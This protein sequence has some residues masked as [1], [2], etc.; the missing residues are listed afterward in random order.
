MDGK[1]FSKNFPS[2][3]PCTTVVMLY[4][5]WLIVCTMRFA[6]CRHH[7]TAGITKASAP[8]NKAHA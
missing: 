5:P 3:S 4:N 7:N 6:A 2:F 1:S 8:H